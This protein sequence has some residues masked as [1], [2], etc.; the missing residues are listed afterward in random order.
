MTIAKSV[1]L[2]VLKSIAFTFI[3]LS[4]WSYFSHFGSSS[5]S[6]K[7]AAQIEAYDN[8]TARITKQLDVVEAQQLRMDQNLQAQETNAKRFSEVLSTWEK[9]SGRKQ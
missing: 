5:S 9:Q 3:F 8:Q 2:F 7:E 4:G 6:A 1:A